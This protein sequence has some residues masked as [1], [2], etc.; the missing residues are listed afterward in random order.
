MKDWFKNE[1]VAAMFYADKQEAADKLYRLV[2]NYDFAFTLEDVTSDAFKICPEYFSKQQVASLSTETLEAAL[3]SGMVYP[4]E[5]SF[6]VYHSALAD[7]DLTKQHAESG[8]SEKKQMWV[9]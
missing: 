8:E 1:G 2:L 3:R 9:K 6:G 4:D 5:D 7:Y